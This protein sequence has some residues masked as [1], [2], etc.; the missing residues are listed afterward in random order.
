MGKFLIEGNYYIVPDEFSYNIA[1]KINKKRGA[2]Y[3]NIAFCSTPEDALRYYLRLKHGESA[4][5]AGDGSIKDLID[6]LTAETKKLSETLEKLVSLYD[7][8]IDP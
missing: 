1:K 8:D 6:T 4:G 3:E 7:P 2:E 5:R